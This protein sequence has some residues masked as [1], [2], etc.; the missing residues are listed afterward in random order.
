MICR[1][2]GSWDRAN[3][4]TECLWPKG[5]DGPCAREARRFADEQS[6]ALDLSLMIVTILAVAGFAVITIGFVGH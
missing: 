5:E 2:C 6:D 1:H 3:W 4:R